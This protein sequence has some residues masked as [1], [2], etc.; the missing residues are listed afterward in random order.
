MEFAALSSGGRHFPP[1]KTPT[2]AP[3]GAIGWPQSLGRENGTCGAACLSQRRL[4]GG[5]ECA[6]RMCRWSRLILSG[7]G[8]MA[9]TVKCWAG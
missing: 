9:A 2:A 8:V 1:E 6:K 4:R 3:A 7:G 5:F